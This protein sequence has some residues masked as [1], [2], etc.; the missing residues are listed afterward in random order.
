MY[1]DGVSLH[2]SRSDCYCLYVNVDTFANTFTPYVGCY[3]LTRVRAVGLVGLLDT[4]SNNMNVK[5]LPTNPTVSMFRIMDDR[6]SIFVGFNGRK[7]G[8]FIL[9]AL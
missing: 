3:T 4:R 2:S 7:S 5:I 1:A 9:L 6:M 8:E